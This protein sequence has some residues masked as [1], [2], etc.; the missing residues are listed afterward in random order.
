MYVHRFA[1]ET[2]VLSYELN[3]KNIALG[4][5]CKHELASKQFKV[6]ITLQQ[7]K[8]TLVKRVC[9]CANWKIL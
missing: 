1:R 4:I 5:D 3:K 2:A 7:R 9:E 6:K 8:K